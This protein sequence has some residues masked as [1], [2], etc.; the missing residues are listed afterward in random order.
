MP[1]HQ[2]RHF[3]ST[4]ED[5]RIYY[6]SNYDVY[7]LDLKTR[8]NTLLATV[9][10]EARCLAAA[11]GWV[12]VGGEVN[13]DCA[14]VKLDK[15]DGDPQ[16]FGNDLHVDVLGGEIVNSMS[17]HYLLNEGD[18]PDE[19]VVL[20]SNNDKTVKIYSLVQRQVLTTLQHRVPVNYAALSPDSTVIAAV[21]DS[22]EVHFYRRRLADEPNGGMGSENKY[23]KYD[24]RLFAAPVVPTGDPVYDDHSFAVCFS[25]S[26]HLCAA[27]SQGGSISVFDMEQLLHNCDQPAESAIIC[28]FRSSRP[29]LW[30][31]VRSMTFSPEPWD[32]LAWAEDHGRVGL[33]DLRRHFVR[34]QILELNKQKVEIVEVEDGTPTAYRGLS[35]KE[36]LK[37]QHST[38]LRSMRELSARGSTA[39]LPSASPQLG[40]AQRRQSRQDLLTYHQGLDLDARERSV[41]DALETTIDDVEHLATSRPYSV[42]YTSSPRFRPSATSTDPRREYDMQLLNPGSRSSSSRT[43]PPRRRASVVL[44][45]SSSN[46]YLAPDEGLRPRLS[47]SPGRMTDDEDVPITSTNDDLTP[48]TRGSDARPRPYNIPMSDPWHVI[49]SALERARD[50]DGGDRPAT[51]AQ[52]E[53]ALEAE[54]RLGNQLERQLAD[55]R[56]LSAH[57]RPQLETRERLLQSQQEQ[58]DAARE[59]GT[60]PEPSLERLRQRELASEQQ[61][62]ERRSQELETEIRLGTN[63]TRRLETERARLLNAA[64]TVPEPSSGGGN[65]HETSAQT[66]TLPTTRSEEHSESLAATLQR[67]ETFRRQRLAHIED[68]ERQVRRAESRVALASS[69]IQALE[70]AI[71]R[72]ANSDRARGHSEARVQAV[73]DATAE[74]NV[75]SD[76]ASSPRVRATARR[77]ELAAINSGHPST[78]RPSELAGRIPVADMQLAR[79]MFLTGV[80]GNRAMD[81]NGNWMPT[82]GWH[83]VLAG[84]SSATPGSLTASVVDVV[85]EMGP[86]T[87]GIGFSPDGRYLYVPPDVLCCTLE[88]TLFLRYAGSEEG[89]F[90]FKVNLRDRMT[91]PAFEMR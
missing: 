75:R 36:K 88:L 8:Q 77:A 42:N 67:H 24:W 23:P 15:E 50:S 30:G 72:G 12:C 47:A 91:F 70:N 61:S 32:L 74:S 80:S 62:S 5:D 3:I 58:L 64:A 78:G 9:P 45:E 73:N 37:Q 51:L 84:S 87:A 14:F 4:A 57:L 13:G 55:E 86:G 81:A 53:A 6:V 39:D 89:I 33:A 38:R 16:C 40:A 85:R 22:D 46:R 44:S 68:L 35:L 69:D 31:C 76:G 25:P 18:A 43:Y 65:S 17:I 52:V 11:H 2:L 34:R 1:H 20:I 90:E 54:R 27:S 83:R 59:D 63:R 49:Q 19:P 41:I 66:S 79:M 60:S 28:S 21:G 10:F 71:Q 7:L 26:G 48:T 56:Q 82:S 29:T